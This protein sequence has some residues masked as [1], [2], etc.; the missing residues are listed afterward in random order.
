[1]S[2]EN[3]DWLKRQIDLYEMDIPGMVKPPKPG[4]PEHYKWITETYK[5]DYD[6]LLERNT[7][8]DTSI[9]A[10][11]GN[12]HTSSRNEKPEKDD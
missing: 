11:G 7:S 8:I 1:M 12:P 4:T 9:G 10:I 2:K 6:K 5:D 3:R